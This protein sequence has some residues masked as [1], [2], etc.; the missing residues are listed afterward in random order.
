[1]S[2]LL[3]HMKKALV[4]GGGIAGMSATIRLREEGVAVDLIDKDPNWSVYG[5]GITLSVLTFRALCDLG[6]GEA[7]TAKGH[8]HDGVTLHDKAGN[9]LREVESPRLFS[10]DMPAEGGILRP[11]LHAIMSA[12]CLALGAEV[13]LGLTVTKLEQDDSGVDVTFSDGSSGRY[14]FVI[15]ADGLF[16]TMRDMVLTDA[17]KPSFTGQA[18]W[19]ILFDTPE[20]WSQGQMFLSPEVKVGFTP[21]SPTQMYMYLLEAV[22][23]NPWREPEELPG[24]LR[25][26]LDGFGGKVSELREQ[27]N[28]DSQIIYRPLESILIDGDW[29]NGRVALI[30]DTVHA[31]TPHLGSGAGM[32]VEDAIVLVEELKRTPVLA[33]AMADFMTRRMPRGKLVVGNS[34]K[35][36]EL[37]MASAPMPEQGK[38]MADSIAAIADPY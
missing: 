31:T 24:L 27:I 15:G 30:G 8:G 18:C 34:L 16:S 25:G 13:R 22:P 17:P 6:L 28:A 20:E 37:E 36:G 3:S 21:C 11:E 7:I 29:Y 33:D 5:A 26:L 38:L 12:R 23:D 1:M 9:F 10:E 19:R 2:H 14:D 32:A 4:V 35:L